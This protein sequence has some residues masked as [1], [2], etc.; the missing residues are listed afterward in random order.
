M[1]TTQAKAHSVTF[2][3]HSYRIQSATAFNDKTAINFV[4]NI[5]PLG[6]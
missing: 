6:S 5:P 2:Y 3:E 1:T 4:N